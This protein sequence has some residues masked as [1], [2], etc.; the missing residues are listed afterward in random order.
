MTTLVY[1]VGHPDRGDDAAGWLVADRLV[2]GPELWVRRVTAD[3]ASLLTDP[4][5]D[6]AE[7]VIIVDA[8][9]TG[10]PVGTVSVLDAG[11]LL[12]GGVP[13]G[14]GTH[15]LGLVTILRLAGALGRLPRDLRVIGIEAREFGAGADADPA[16]YRAAVSVADAINGDALASLEA[17]PADVAEVGH[18]SG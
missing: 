7:H 2:A 10:A 1:G 9:C 15:D 18:V 5:W 16:V 12:A 13:T 11:E 8:V 6:D 4:A 3:P 17:R 14:G